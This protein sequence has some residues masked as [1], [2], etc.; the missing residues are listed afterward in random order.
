M[1]LT[2]DGRALAVCRWGTPSGL[3][4]VGL[5][6]A[7]GCRLN[8]VPDATVLADLDYLTYDRPGYGRST[9]HAGR[10]VADCAADVRAIV[11]RAGWDRFAVVGGS[12]GAPHALACAALLPER[13]VGLSLVVPGGSVHQMGEERYFA[14]MNA[15]NAR[16]F[17][18]ALHE[19][20]T[21]EPSLLEDER[22]RR[23][24][25]PDPVDDHDRMLDDEAMRAGVGG[26]LDDT[27]AIHTDWGFTPS[28]VTV[29]VDIWYG[30]DDTYAPPGHALWLAGLLPDAKVHPQHGGHSWPARKMPEIFASLVNRSWPRR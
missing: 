4:V 5:H 18:A 24:A 28:S 11:D 25:P 3:P 20:D 8:A 29:P 12:A 14:G 27:L 1:T 16:D 13:V 22:R 2:V 10:T 6:G 19:P 15:E 30:V 26:L 21:L 17:R 23:A 7:P 9:R